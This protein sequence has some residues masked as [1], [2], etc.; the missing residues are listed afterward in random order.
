ML[1]TGMACALAAGA[2]FML[3]ATWAAVPVSTTHAI[4]GA[5]LGMTLVGAGAAC[6]RWGYPGL[7]AIVASWFISPLFAGLLS[8]ALLLAIKHFVFK[9]SH[10]S[11]LLSTLC[12]FT[13]LSR[14]LCLCQTVPVTRAA[15][16]FQLFEA[17]LSKTC[18]GILIAV[19]PLSV[20][21]S[22]IMSCS[23]DYLL[24]LVCNGRPI[25]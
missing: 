4:V 13:G 2:F 9:V 11:I 16:S 25:F 15:V 10:F 20:V 14:G 7:V 23:S 5:V 21:T 19:A 18:P 12:I 24:R 17:A 8:G 6:V 3:V 1:C 22:T